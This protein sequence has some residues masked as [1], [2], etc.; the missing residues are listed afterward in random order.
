MQAAAPGRGSW[1]DCPRGGRG[2]RHGHLGHWPVRQLG[3]DL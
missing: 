1:E 3:P 2:G